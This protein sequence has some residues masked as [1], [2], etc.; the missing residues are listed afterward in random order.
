MYAGGVEEFSV[1]QDTC[2]EM[3]DLHLICICPTVDS[4][5]AGALV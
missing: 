3:H 2:H 1:G 5:G 4:M